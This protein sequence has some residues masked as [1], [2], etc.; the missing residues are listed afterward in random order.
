VRSKS[1]GGSNSLRQSPAS[2]TQV[3]SHKRTP[4]SSSTNK[5]S[6]IDASLTKQSKNN[7]IVTNQ[8]PRQVT[9]TSRSRS[10]RSSHHYIDT[11]EEEPELMQLLLSSGISSAP[12]KRSAT[13]NHLVLANMGGRSKG[14]SPLHNIVSGRSGPGHKMFFGTSPPPP[15]EHSPL[16]AIQ[17]IPCTDLEIAQVLPPKSEIQY[18]VRP[19]YTRSNSNCMSPNDVFSIRESS[20]GSI[21]SSEGTGVISSTSSAFRSPVQVSRSSGSVVRLR[22]SAELEVMESTSGGT[23][24]FRSNR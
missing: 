6:T 3:H 19:H 23:K 10:N 2:A 4:H 16:Q 9:D 8:S 12:N 21:S 18:Y 17:V 13:P 11:A 15:R 24:I 1:E 22:K 5:P 20:G 14:T 7:S